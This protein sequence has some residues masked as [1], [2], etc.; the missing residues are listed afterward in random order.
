MSLSPHDVALTSSI[1]LSTV[2]VCCCLGHAQVGTRSTEFL[3]RGHDDFPSETGVC[4]IW[5]RKIKEV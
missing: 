2:G 1:Y 5:E 4:V 3:Q